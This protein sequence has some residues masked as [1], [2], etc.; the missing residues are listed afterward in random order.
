M[1]DIKN[2]FGKNK[3]TQVLSD[4]SLQK[5]GAKIE[6]VDYLKSNLKQK[7]RFIPY[8]DFSSASNFARY[9]SAEKYYTDSINYI[10]NEYPYD[11]SLRE[12]IDW[13]LSGSYFDK[14]LFDNE[15]PRTNGFILVGK[16]YGTP[17]ADAG[18]YDTFSA[19]SK[20]Y[21]FVKGSPHPAI[22]NGSLRND[23]KDYN[24][25]NTSSFGRYNLEIQ[26][27]NGLTLEFWLN[28]DDYDSSDESSKEIVFD[29]WNSG[30]FGNSDYGRF[31]VE[32]TGGASTDVL[33]PVFNIELRSGSAGFSYRSDITG[34]HST[35]ISLSSSVSLTG[36]WNHYALSFQN[37]GS[38][39]FGKL[40]CNGQL[41]HS[42]VAGSS[43]GQVTGSM[44]ATIG[45]LVTSVSGTYGAIG[46]GKLSASLDDFRY[47]RRIR[48]SEKIGKYWFTSV[49]GGT[50]SDITNAA[51]ASTKY[52]YENPL[53]LGVYYKFNE[54]INNT[55][56]SV[57]N[58]AIILDYSGRTTNGAWT[59]YTYGS[60]FTGSAMVISKAAKSEF[61][62]PIIYS[63]HPDVVSLRTDKTA[64]GLVYDQQNNASLYHSFPAWIIEEDESNNSDGLKDLTQILGSYFDTL[65][66]QIEAVP[67]LKELKY[68]SGS[69]KP[70]PFADK[71]VNSLGFVT[72][73]VLENATALEYFASRNDVQSYSKKLN[74]TKNIIYQNIYN[75]LNYI[76]KTKGTEKSFRN[77]IRCYGIDE[78]LVKLNLY[79]SNTSYEFRDNKDF[80]VVK[81]RYADFNKST[82]FGAT[83]F[84]QTS[85]LNVNSRE[86]VSS[87]AEMIFRGNTYE[88]EVIFPDKL[89][90][91]SP[92]Y[93]SNDF[94]TASIYGC[95]TLGTSGNWGSPD[96]GN[97]QVQS[98]RPGIHSSD[99]YFQLTGSSGGFFPLLTSSVFRNVYDDSKWNFAVKIKPSKYPQA[100]G[101]A[102]S[103]TGSYDIEFSGYNYVLD[104]LVNSFEASSTISSNGA[105]KFL[106]ANKRFFVGAHRTNF[107]GGILQRA[108][109]K[110]SSARV[111]MDYLDNSV[112]KAHAQD[113]GNFGSQYPYKNAYI[114]QMSQSLGDNVVNI[115][116]METLALY[117]DFETITGSNASGQFV[118]PDVSS[119][120]VSLANRWGWL[121][122]IAKYQHTGLGYDFEASDTGSIDRR[123]VQ[124]AKQQLP[125]VGN[126]SDMVSIIDDTTNQI[127]TRD[128]RPIDYYFAF[129]KSMYGIVSEQI[130]NYFGTIVAF[131]D[132][133]GAPVNRYRQD[134]KDLEKLRSL[135][136]ERVQNTPDFEKFMEYYKWI[137]SSIGLMLQQLIPASANFTE[138]LRN[139]VESHVLERNKY[140]NKFPTLEMKASDPE[141][142][143]R[144]INE[145]LYSGKR[146]LA[147][148][149]TTA[150]DSNCEWWLDRTE[151]NNPNITSGV[152]SVD[153][154]RNTIRR[155]N[156]FKSGS[157]PT[158][159]VS[160]DSTSTTTTYTGQAYALRNFTKPYKL[161][162]DESPEIHGGSNFAKNKTVEYTHEAL[163]F[164]SSEQ[165]TIAA[166]SVPAKEGCEDV[167]DPN[168]KF[169]LDAKVANS[170]DPEGYLSGKSRIFA[171]F[172]IYSSSVQSGYESVFL[173]D[174]NRWDINN[175]HDDIYGDDKGIPVQ[176]PFTEAHVGG[177]QHRHVN[178]NTASTDTTLTRPE[179]WDLSMDANTLTISH[180]S[181]HQPRA[182]M[183][184]DAYAKRPLN[185]ANIKWGT[186]SQVA[187]NYQHDYQIVQTSGRKINNRYFVKSEGFVPDVNFVTA[188]STYLSGVIDYALPRYD[189]TGSNKFIFVERFSAPGGP[190]VTRGN[191]D[192]NSEEFGI[193]N[194]L[195]YRNLT[196]RNALQSWQTEHCG[197]FG[198]SPTGSPGD[199]T[200][201]VEHRTNALSYD[202][203]IASYHKI[204]RNPF[205][206]A[207]N[208]KEQSKY[209]WWNIVDGCAVPSYQNN[210]VYLTK[211]LNAGTS[212]NNGVAISEQRVGMNGF[213]EFQVH[214]PESNTDYSGSVAVGFFGVSSNA[215]L[216]SIANITLDWQTV[217]RGRIYC[218]INGG[219][220][221]TVSVPNG[222]L[223]WT[224]NE[225]FRIVR[226]GDNIYFQ[227]TSGSNVFKDFFKTQLPYDGPGSYTSFKAGA[228]LYH[229]GNYSYG[230]SS[231]KNVKISSG[232]YDNWYVQHAIPQ[233]ELQ[234]AWIN[235]SY[236]LYKSQPSGYASNYSVPSGSTSTTA[237][238]VQFSSASNWGF[239]PIENGELYPVNYVNMLP[240]L[241]TSLK[242]PSAYKY[243]L[244]GNIGSKSRVKAG[245][246]DLKNVTL[247]ENGT[248]LTKTSADGWD[249]A[250]AGTQEINGNG[251]IEF[252]ADQ[253]DAYLFVG[254]NDNPP[255]HFSGGSPAYLA[256]SDMEYSI[257][258]QASDVEIWEDGSSVFSLGAG[259]Y[260]VGWK[261]R[262]TRQYNNI[263][264]QHDNGT[265]TWTTFY[266]SSKPIITKLLPDASIHEEGAS[267]S[268]IVVNVS[269]DNNIVYPGFCFFTGSDLAASGAIGTYL[270]NLNG[271]YGYPS[272]KQIRTGE[273]PVARYHKNNNILSILKS[274]STG[275]TDQYR[276]FVQPPVEFKYRPLNTVHSAPVGETVSQ[277]ITLRHTYGNNK[278]LF[279]E[280]PTNDGTSDSGSIANWLLQ[281]DTNGSVEVYDRIV[282]DAS[283]DADLSSVEYREIIY[284][285]STNTGLA[286]TRGRIGYAEVANGT[287]N[288]DG[289]ISASLS[290]GT[291]GIDR[292][293]LE[294][295]TYWRNQ[296]KYRNRRSGITP[297]GANLGVVA[298]GGS[299]NESKWYSIASTLPNSQ[300]YY[301]GF[302]T[303]IYGLGKT[304][305]VAE[306]DWVFRTGLK[307]NWAFSNY[308]I[309]GGVSINNFADM[310][311][312]NSANAWTWEGWAGTNVSGNVPAGG[313]QYTSVHYP[314]ASA[315]Y[316]HFPA[317]SPGQFSA[318][319]YGISPTQHTQSL[320]AN[321]P[322]EW[323]TEELSGKKPF[324]DSYKE[325]AEDIRGLG[326]SLTVI[327]EFKISEHM[328][329]YLKYNF[330]SQNDKILSLPGG[331]ITSSANI[332]EF[333]APTQFPAMTLPTG[334][335]E[336]DEKFFNDYSNSDFQKYFG[337]FEGSYPDEKSEITL[338]CNGVK[339]LLP[340][341]GFYPQQRTLQLASL[342]SQSIAPYVNG[343]GWRHG[344]S[345]GSSNS[346]QSGALALQSLLQPYYAPGIM[347][348]TIK[349]GI[350]VDWGALTGSSLSLAGSGVLTNAAISSS[351]NYRIGFESILDPL[352]SVGLPASASG[353]SKMFLLTPTWQYIQR[354]NNYAGDQ[355]YQRNSPR[356][357][358]TSIDQVKRTAAK[359]TKEYNL[360]KAATNNFFA[361]IPNFFLQGEKLKAIYSK[362]QGDVGQ[363][364]QE[365]YDYYMN[366]TLEKTP[367]LV[368]MQED[369]QDILI[370]LTGA[371]GFRD[372]PFYDGRLF[373]PPVL[374]GMKETWGKTEFMNGDATPTLRVSAP[375]YAPYTPPYFYGKSVMTLKFS[376]NSSNVR[377]NFSWNKYFNEV[378]MSFS[379][380]RMDAMFASIAGSD[381]TSNPSP[382]KA[383]AMQITSSIKW[384]GLSIQREVIRDSLGKVKEVRE[385]NDSLRQ[386]VISPFMETPVLDF[387][388]NSYPP[389]TGPRGMWSGYGSIPDNASG[390]KLSVEE[391]LEQVEFSSETA[392]DFAS[393]AFAKG[394]AREQKI[395]QVNSAGKD[396]SEAIVAI[397]YLTRPT[398]G[399]EAY[400]TENTFLDDRYFF[401]LR[402]YPGNAWDASG[403]FKA[404]KTS[405]DNSDGEVAISEDLARGVPGRPGF[406]GLFDGRFPELGTE[407]RAIRTTSISEMI[408]TMGDYVLPPELDFYTYSKEN[409]PNDFIEPFAMYMFEFKHHLDQQDLADIWQGLMPK[410]STDA[411]LDS[412]A[413]SHKRYPII[414]FFGD[415]EIPEDIRW[416]VFK[417]KKKANKDYYKLTADVTDDEKFSKDFFT[418]KNGEI[419]Y[420]YNWPYDYFSL[421]ELA[422]LE[423]GTKFKK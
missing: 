222:Y 175:Y 262:I 164:D 120:S 187:G 369:N 200:S 16:N 5:E 19:A 51:S 228:W 214:E 64:E 418:T 412:T 239:D 410:I 392:K 8:I 31:R 205:V 62:D 155:A 283:L 325:Y 365:G 98:V 288:A 242:S 180:R 275:R 230:R 341:D 252:T 110:I 348:N 371:A 240:V 173:K 107:D 137:D 117:W 123:Y 219:T 422:D 197:Q 251:Y 383:S 269:R 40:Y 55:T 108:D 36:S 182:T 78:E 345:D 259:V 138:D 261:F 352:G 176:G 270:N 388:S 111:W 81:K 29:L 370:P 161:T 134:Y 56:A 7:R 308:R 25:Y 321:R 404:I 284:P 159:A 363:S 272:W 411:K 174:F 162:V 144:G 244:F 207:S 20:E 266:K 387:S 193:Y 181:A 105:R 198:I 362:N 373:G 100:D 246:Y 148:I 285:R 129:E 112:I 382:A 6:S 224:P 368:M 394:A 206:N 135:Y 217:P 167:I 402:A 17:I 233:S 221:H 227:R 289:T 334:I 420:S 277:P 232:R 220:V 168:S 332:E 349:S 75:N 72:S 320:M 209:V 114:S 328:P 250:A 14:H 367:D 378:S 154:D 10:S 323:R 186:G 49:N 140:W 9:G 212:Y 22:G 243:G 340:Y 268:G 273:T 106:S 74:E 305:I 50:N 65:Q 358:W 11:G 263:F 364:L 413:I 377:E 93:V 160:R 372:V 196:V 88:A 46:A 38:Q 324:F 329:Y 165:L 119:G 236:D 331:N 57:P 42:V 76:F 254:L 216:D 170:T 82:R 77:L 122:P 2:L 282:A 397:P 163:K 386:W 109:S 264:Y 73:E 59:G 141:A 53:D 297:G 405:L 235:D 128:S 374:A 58:D 21:I 300:G 61:K 44:I 92:Y 290:N 45:S 195:N 30:T 401:S 238:A 156:D 183:I 399:D 299:N 4:S 192:T 342:F 125:E 210:D 318:S 359:D 396:I 306:L 80:R 395:G 327:P 330:R 423:V 27:D 280:G 202:G 103:A 350:A 303:S 271:P 316:Y 127:F 116:Q 194:G 309:S 291:N 414:E 218:T 226:E 52:S 294:R 104:V 319:A 118:V 203:V 12:K 136:F 304:P 23:W 211:L 24:L 26:G 361:E 60:R 208:V 326:K 344:A 366:I 199:G 258:L 147:P 356:Q 307:Q 204:N 301:D 132:L 85:S 260:Q 314:T 256:F 18:G 302:A 69:N 390:V 83:V 381:Y 71:L 97:F 142:G 339:K 296:A 229:D 101:V 312:L 354:G 247:T 322:L 355:T 287:L 68:P 149:P 421:V 353:N 376:A 245:W 157:G 257:E 237:S 178:V 333:R 39:M 67:K 179:A 248:K 171:P 409:S 281:S 384:D 66:L 130:I 166:A 153:T 184:R 267:I 143:L 33:D 292:G 337:E 338:R 360:Y 133:I 416:M 70:Y 249:G 96:V 311:E 201:P 385:Q 317:L 343:I 139:M 315:Y 90:F 255:A 87:S 223:A 400:T 13:N 419:P 188:S 213:V 293:P 279:S 231:V 28:K 189:L 63:N 379:N 215:Y 346:A 124:S 298:L 91:N 145:M 34:P 393:I 274:S 131:N 115:P 389:A 95:H 152:S 146:G 35:T 417:V 84:Q 126:S 398:T 41:A 351:I 336:L 121:G 47:W 54:G 190:E 347:Y 191:L 241:P 295:R 253:T 403:V 172:S 150:T 79:A 15:Y 177:R 375:G 158:L 276:N 185:I 286:Q 102:G 113:V 1:S 48:T 43:I 406:T 335:R 89:D 99:A 357:P 37:T 86:Y 94:V 391:S 265:D 310:G 3:N 169:K 415:R 380:E 407:P 225:R 313:L 408:N 151:R 278:C 234:Y 32:L